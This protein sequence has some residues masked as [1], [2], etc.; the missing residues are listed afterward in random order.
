MQH[1]LQTFLVRN[2][3]NYEQSTIT[4]MKNRA[5]ILFLRKQPHLTQVQLDH[6]ICLYISTGSNS[7]LHA[8]S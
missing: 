7:N 2:V 5:T 6:Y 1:E 3:I 4:Q 8:K